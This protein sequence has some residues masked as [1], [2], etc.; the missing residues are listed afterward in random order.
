M[1]TNALN[2]TDSEINSLREKLVELE[3]AKEELKR[4]QIAALPAEFGLSTIDELIGLLM[5][6]KNPKIKLKAPVTEVRSYHN[7]GYQSRQ[8]RKIPSIIR[9]QIAEVV[10][11]G[12]LTNFETAKRFK[13]SL[14]TLNNIKREFG[15]TR[16]YQRN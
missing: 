15:L 8:G 4:Q 10:K 7:Q 5:E 6:E 11:R 1:N 14:P 2:E 12:E 16:S 9:K 13:V 3:K